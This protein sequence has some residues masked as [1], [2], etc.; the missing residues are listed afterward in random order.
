MYKLFQQNILSKL[1]ASIIIL[2]L[3]FQPLLIFAQ[4]TQSENPTATQ[5]QYTE[6]EQLEM[7]REDAAHKAF[8]DS[9]GYK[10]LGRIDTDEEDNPQT[11]LS[12]NG[13]KKVTKQT[14]AK[15]V[16]ASQPMAMASGGG[17][18]PTGGLDYASFTSPY[19][20]T[21]DGKFNPSG[22]YTSQTGAFI[23]SIPIISPEGRNG[24][25]PSISINYSSQNSEEHNF[26]GYG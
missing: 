9:G 6:A 17:G 7:E 14:T 25:T 24:L 11:S 15:V 16:S 13:E 26:F 18:D 22:K 2:T 12:Q 20:T 5:Q 8:I 21:V 10:A 3:V 4:T 1:L 19:S 23:Y